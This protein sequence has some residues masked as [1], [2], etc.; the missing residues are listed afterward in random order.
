MLLENYILVYNGSRKSMQYLASKP[1]LLGIYDKMYLRAINYF[2]FVVLHK[3]HLETVKC[4]TSGMWHTE[5]GHFSELH[6][7]R[8]FSRWEWDNLANIIAYGFISPLLCQLCLASA[9][10]LFDFLPDIKLSSSTPLWTVAIPVT[11]YLSCSPF[12]H[13]P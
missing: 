4:L 10:L 3:S 1:Q 7:L 11:R 9:T 13:T 2:M 12:Y 8:S 6:G 5:A